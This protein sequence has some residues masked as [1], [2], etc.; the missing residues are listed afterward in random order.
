MIFWFLSIL[1]LWSLLLAYF[2][3]SLTLSV[4]WIPVFQHTLHY[5]WLLF[6]SSHVRMWELDH[7]EDCTLKNWCFQTVVLEKT[8]ECPLDCKKSKPI[9]P[10]GNKHW[11]WKDWCWSSNTLATWCEELTLEKILMLGKIES[12][13]R[14]GWQRMRWLDGITDSV[15]RIWANSGT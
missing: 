8:L 4:K 9:N 15:D 11:I 3:Y 2:Y 14:R 13:R 12:K 6:S 7:K 1:L 10:K 5:L